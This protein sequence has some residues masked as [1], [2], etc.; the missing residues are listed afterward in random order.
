VT[1]EEIKS[2]SEVDRRGIRDLQDG[3][4]EVKFG[5]GE[6]GFADHELQRRVVV[7]RGHLH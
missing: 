7:R 3:L 1:E 5:R 4:M 2:L 6:I